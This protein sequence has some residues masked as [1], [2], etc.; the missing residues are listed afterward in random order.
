M[1]KITT[2]AQ[3]LQQRSFFYE[4]INTLGIIILDLT[5]DDIIKFVGKSHPLSL[6]P[7]NLTYDVDDFVCGHV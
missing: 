4:D 6:P 5:A 2:Q 7:P 1:A 3:F